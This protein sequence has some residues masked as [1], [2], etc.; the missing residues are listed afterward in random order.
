MYG[1]LEKAEDQLEDQEGT[2]LESIEA[3][4]GWE[5]V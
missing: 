3:V 5:G 2:W 4:Q 1:V